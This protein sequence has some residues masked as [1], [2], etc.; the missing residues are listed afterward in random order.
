MKPCALYSYTCVIENVLREPGLQ[1]ETL[2]SLNSLTQEQYSRRI[3]D[4]C[5]MI[6][7]V[8]LHFKEHLNVCFKARTF[9]TSVRFALLRLLALCYRWAPDNLFKCS[10]I[11]FMLAPSPFSGAAGLSISNRAVYQKR[12][13]QVLF[14]LSLILLKKKNLYFVA[15][16]EV[17]I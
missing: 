6:R 8:S 3:Q 1:W 12:L 16:T 10:E 5:D 2:W 9:G 11:T 4:V 15:L 13:I 14:L 17:Y 7:V